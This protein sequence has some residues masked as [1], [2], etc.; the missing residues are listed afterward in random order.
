[1]P[2]LLNR[3]ALASVGNITIIPMQD[4]LELG[5]D[6]RMNTPGTTDKN[7]RWKFSWEQVPNDLPDRIKRALKLYQR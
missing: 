7:W 6:H 4:C 5:S 1:M 2:W 3:L